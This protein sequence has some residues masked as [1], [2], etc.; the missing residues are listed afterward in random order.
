[1]RGLRGGTLAGDTAASAASAR[2]REEPLRAVAGL[3]SAAA[4]S[5]WRGRSGRRVVVAVHALAAVDPDDLDGTVA[6]AVVRPEAG[7]ARVRA[8]TTADTLATPGRRRAWLERAAAGGATEIHLH[9]LAETADARR[10]VAADL[11]MRG[12]GEQ[13]GERCVR[14]TGRTRR[15]AP[16]RD[17]R[18]LPVRTAPPRDQAGPRRRGTR[19]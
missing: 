17:D 2:A 10:A 14:R 18:T 8:A 3:P 15:G 5:A 19:R 13:A 11:G 12:T 6:L 7:P 16:E 4:L 9:R 1:M